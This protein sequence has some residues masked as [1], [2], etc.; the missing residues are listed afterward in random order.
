MRALKIILSTLLI[1]STANVYAQDGNYMNLQLGISDVDGFDT[2][3]VAI[4]TYGMHLPKVHENFSVEGEITNTIDDPNTTVGGTSVDISY[5]TLG[6][7]AVYAFPVSDSIKLR[8]RAGLLYYDA[9]VSATGAGIKA[10]DD[11]I[12]LTFGIGATFNLNKK[13]DIIAE[14]THIESDISHLSAGIQYH[15]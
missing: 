7:Y 9:S 6:A 5:Y 11:G 1:A 13:M 14:Y 3:F 2:G 8:G 15:F 4:G 10:S 12:E